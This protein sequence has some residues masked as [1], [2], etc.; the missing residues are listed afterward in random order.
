MRRYYASV[1]WQALDVHRLQPYWT[2]AQC[3]AALERIEGALSEAM[4]RAGW[5][6]LEQLIGV[7]DQD[8]YDEVGCGGFGWKDMPA[9]DDD[10]DDDDDEDQDEDLDAE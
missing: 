8:F 9:D 10:D 5:D 6:C 7:E 4:C 1:E 3:A 2:K